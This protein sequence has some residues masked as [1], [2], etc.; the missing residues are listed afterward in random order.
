MSD[1]DA[2]HYSQFGKIVVLKLNQPERHNTLSTDIL[3]SLGNYLG[4]VANNNMVRAVIITG[5]GKNFS[6]GGDFDEF[7]QA[8]SQDQQY[9]RDYSSSRTATLAAVICAIYEMDCPVIAAVNGQAAGAGFSLALSCDLRLVD[10]KVRFNFAYGSLGASTDGGMSWLLP[11]IVGY[12]KAYQLLLEQPIIRAP[13][14]LELGLVSEIVPVGLLLSRSIELAEQFSKNALHSNM[15]A[16]RQ[17]RR[18]AH[19]SL[20]EH[21]LDE[22]DEFINGLLSED[23]QR[24][25]SSRGKGEL[26]TF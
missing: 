25:L 12:S 22:H 3:N 14:A 2:I 17:L 16:K 18:A 4:L 8:L 19:R 10:E 1:T 21:I 6:L 5:S 9:C 24:A 7:H 26:V 13:R 11:R 15:A 23:M 20:Q